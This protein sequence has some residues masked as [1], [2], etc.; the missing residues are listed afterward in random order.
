MIDVAQ[1]D[2]DV[3]L[4]SNVLENGEFDLLPNYYAKL[5]AHQSTLRGDQNRMKD[6]EIPKSA[7]PAQELLTIQLDKLIFKL[8]GILPK[9]AESSTT[10]VYGSK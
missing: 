2:I 3:Q 9:N 5:A 7:R 4:F 6:I 8:R 1:A 10:Y